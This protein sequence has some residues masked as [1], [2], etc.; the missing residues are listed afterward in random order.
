VQYLVKMI[1]KKN[2]I[3]MFLILVIIVI[4]GYFVVSTGS[5][6]NNSNISVTS[7][8]VQVVKMYVSG[9]N[10]IF[11]PSSVVKERPVRIE[12]D[13]TRMPGCAKS[14][15]GSEIGL[16]KTFSSR[17]NTFT[18]TPTKAGTFYIACSMNMYTGNLIVTD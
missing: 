17:D 3:W 1:I 7:G 13:M 11:E 15:I 5:K 18:F 9:A 10:Y 2:T 16:R 8:D 6:N 12:A 4:A 14:V